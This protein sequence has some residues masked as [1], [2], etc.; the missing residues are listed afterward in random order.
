MSKQNFT[1]LKAMY[2]NCT[3]K[4]SP[5]LTHTQGLM[6]VSIKIMEKEGVQV[7]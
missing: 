7:D 5:E 1:G 6:D 4:K 2:V 3:L